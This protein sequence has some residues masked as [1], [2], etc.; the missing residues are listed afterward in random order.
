MS[1]AAA[2]AAVRVVR[3]AAVVGVQQPRRLDFGK[4]H[5]VDSL[6]RLNSKKIKL[7]ISKAHFRCGFANHIAQWR[8]SLGTPP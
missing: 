5:I 2:A 7:L 3:F 8:C 4:S 1:L 6:E